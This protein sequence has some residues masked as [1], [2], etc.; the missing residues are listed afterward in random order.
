[1]LTAARLVAALLFAALSWFAA[2]LVVDGLRGDLFGESRLYPWFGYTM[3]L[4]GLWQ[5]WMVM[6]KLVGRGVR[7]SMGNGLRTS[8]QI[9]I[10]GLGYFAIREMFV[11]AVNLRYT[12]FGVAVFE[13]LELF[14]AY[15]ADLVTVPVA[16][17]VMVLG[18]VLSGILTEMASRLWR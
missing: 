3:G 2:T 6:G 7:A 5:G 18:G 15:S 17:G 4:I 14:I 9:M 1:M 10:I 8:V 13:A 16:I 11:Q 12:D